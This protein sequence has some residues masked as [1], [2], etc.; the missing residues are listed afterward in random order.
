MVEH[1]AAC[2]PWPRTQSHPCLFLPF[3]GIPFPTH[4]GSSLPLYA[5][6][7]PLNISLSLKR[8]LLAGDRFDYKPALVLL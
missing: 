1:R 6:H 3:F 2:S 7:H 4:V 5:F 8:P